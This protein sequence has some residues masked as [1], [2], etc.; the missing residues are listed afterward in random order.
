MRGRGLPRG[1]R[2][3]IRGLLRSVG[4]LGGAIVL[5]GCGGADDPVDGTTEAGALVCS[6][7]G[8]ARG[9]SI[10]DVRV[11]SSR[12]PERRA[13]MPSADITSVT[14]RRGEGG[15]ICVTFRTSGPIRLGSG[16]A[17]TTRQANGTAASFD[18]QRYDVQLDPDGS[19]DV[20]RPHGEPRYPVRAEVE[21]DGPALRVDMETLLRSDEG[22]RWRAESSYMP[23]FPLGDVYVDAMPNGEGWSRFPAASG[24]SPP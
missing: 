23:D 16:F 8:S 7:G 9:D 1:N 2:W 18:E 19:Q 6:A 24:M 22:F 17:L 20:S 14:I 5:T 10:G 3:T 15:V 4:A 11:I 12:G 21:R 13:Q